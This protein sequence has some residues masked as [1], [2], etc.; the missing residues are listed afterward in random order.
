[1]DEEL[2][3]TNFKF[4]SN[5]YCDGKRILE[6]ENEWNKNQKAQVKVGVDF[7]VGT[8]DAWFLLQCFWPVLRL[9]EEVINDCDNPVELCSE[10]FRNIQ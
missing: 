1:M 9:V 7:G 3:R 10:S 2:D 4:K 6:W 8:H 5:A